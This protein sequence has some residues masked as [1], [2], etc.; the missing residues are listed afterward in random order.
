MPPLIVV[1]SIIVW[2]IPLPLGLK[3]FALLNRIIEIAKAKVS[4]SL[5]FVIGTIPTVY[6]A[7]K[8]FCHS[9]Q[10]LSSVVILLYTIMGKMSIVKTHKD[11]A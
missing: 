7:V 1:I 10:F 4:I 11:S 5:I 9:Y 2:R 3:I 8:M 6:R